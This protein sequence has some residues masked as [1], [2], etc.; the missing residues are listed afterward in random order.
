MQIVATQVDNAQSAVSFDFFN[1]KSCNV[2]VPL[3]LPNVS[4][5][6]ELDFSNETFCHVAVSENLESAVKKL[7]VKTCLLHSIPEKLRPHFNY[8]MWAR[9]AQQNGDIWD[10]ELCEGAVAVFYKKTDGCNCCAS[11]EGG[12]LI[13][14]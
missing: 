12:C 11:Q 3:D 1:E 5:D 2:N 4:L 9:G 6:L 10:L 13:E 8:A 7:G 14:L